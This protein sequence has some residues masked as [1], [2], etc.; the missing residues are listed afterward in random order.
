[1]EM[2]KYYDFIVIDPENQCEH[3]LHKLI[4]ACH[5]DYFQAIFDSTFMENQLHQTTIQFPD[6]RR[7][8][9]HLFRFM[10]TGE[11]PV[12]TNTAVPMLQQAEYYQVTELIQLLRSEIKNRLLPKHVLQIL[13]DAV[14]FQMHEM[15]TMASCVLAEHFDA[16]EWDAH[17]ENLN[18]L[19]IDIMLDILNNRALTLDTEYRVYRVIAS[20][21][22]EWDSA[23][24][25]NNNNNNN[26]NTSIGNGLA[27]NGRRMTE[28]DCLDLYEKVYFEHL[29]VEQLEEAYENPHVPR[30]LLCKGS[31]L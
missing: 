3:R 12:S 28:Q 15:I 9:P 16:V 8:L 4:L 6:P 24:N 20:Y 14:Q 7:L 5:S 31:I 29:T 22:T 10:Y 30:S 2:G 25:N 13:K 21:T 27:I 26:N 19:P 23:Y 17:E 18:F 11:L 1:M